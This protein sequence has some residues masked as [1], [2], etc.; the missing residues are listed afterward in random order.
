MYQQASVQ[1]ANGGK[2]VIMLFEGAIRFTKAGIEGIQNRK[3]DIA[4]T[5]LKKAQSIINELI[6][7]LNYE[8]EI[9]NELFQIYE[10]MVHQ[11]IQS[12][13]KKDARFAEEVI[14]HL[15]ELL[16]TWKQVVK[17]PAGSASLETG[18]L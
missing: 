10:Y 13:L 9:S 5:N 11:L 16:G 3:Y 1:T 17:A 7:S 4:N 15:Q 6:A 12:N 2:L 8:Y 14:V 18:V